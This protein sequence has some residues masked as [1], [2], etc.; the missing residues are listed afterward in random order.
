MIYDPP[1]ALITVP[2]VITI[3]LYFLTKQ[4]LLTVVIHRAVLLL[5]LD[6]NLIFSSTPFPQLEWFP[7]GESFSSAAMA[8]PAANRDF[9]PLGVFFLGVSFDV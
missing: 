3:S 6:S 2:K 4:K 7:E 8:E 9:S 5:V 1:T